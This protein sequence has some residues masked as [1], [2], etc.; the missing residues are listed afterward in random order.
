MVSSLTNSILYLTTV[1]RDHKTEWTPRGAS[2][3]MVTKVV[4][5]RLLAVI[6]AAI[7]SGI[8]L[9]GLWPLT[10][11]PKNQVAWLESGNGLRFGPYG[12]ILSADAFNPTDLEG[13][14]P[15]S[16]EIWSKPRSI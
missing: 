15:C 6:C 1:I 3:Q 14:A 16:L 12:T 13:G 4:W 2:N 8:L 10:P 11:H 7:L 9:V 5:D